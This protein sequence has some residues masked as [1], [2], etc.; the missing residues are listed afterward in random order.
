MPGAPENHCRLS[1][2]LVTYDH[3]TY[4]RQALRALFKQEMDGPIE[5]VIA[6]D[7]SSDRTVDII[8][9]YEEADSRFHFKYLGD[10]SHLGTTRNYQ[11]GFAACTGEYVAILEGDDYWITPKK[12]QRQYGFLEAHWECDL[13]AVNYFMYEQDRAR[14][15]PLAVIGNGHQ[16]FGA[17]DLI[18]NNPVGNFSAC[19]YRKAALDALP[20]GLFELES[21]DWIVNIC[22]SRTSLTGFLEEPMS[23]YRRHSGGVWTQKSDTAK[24]ARQLHLIPAYDALTN[25]QFHEEFVAL[26]RRLQRG[27]S[28]TTA[29]HE[30]RT[31]DSVRRFQAQILTRM[32]DLAD[33]VPPV[34][35]TVGR[36]LVP[37][38]MQRRLV[39]MIQGTR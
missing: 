10:K 33:F 22:V 4:I 34:L 2:L 35:I 14:F 19:M 12:L 30:C 26:A 3:E 37:V 11:R 15:T 38:V 27:I 17:R 20:Q 23:V 28:V 21:Y 6:D 13:C 7:G 1:V 39:R 31:D 32:A 24:L 8:R 9:E 36:A 25:Q 5:L 18:A 16:Y 29:S